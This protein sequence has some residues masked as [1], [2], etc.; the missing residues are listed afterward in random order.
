MR[1]LIIKSS[2]LTQIRWCVGLLIPIVLLTSTSS[3][4]QNNSD[5]TEDSQLPKTD[6]YDY[7]GTHGV[8]TTLG[9]AVINGDYA[10]PEFGIYM[11][12]GYKKSIIPHVNVNLTFNKFNLV[13]EDLFNKGFMSFDVNAEVLAFPHERF[14]P[15]IFFGGGANASNYFEA[16]DPKVQGGLG[17]EYII[18]EGLSLRIFGDYNHV[19][20]DELDG[21]IYGDADDVYWRMGCGLNFY[22]G[23]A[24]KKAK[25]LSTVP[26]IIKTNPIP[27][28][29]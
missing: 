18:Y 2:F 6:F 17:L 19:F 28:D 13:Y 5:S 22:F 25:L 8:S 24:K 20:S 15:F 26:T 14:S 12:F 27:A 29:N 10:N 3:L 9:S 11:G 1:Y 4:A 7:R 23:G 21:K 16:V